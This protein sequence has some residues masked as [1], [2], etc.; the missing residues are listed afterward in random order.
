MPTALR[1]SVFVIACL[2]LS[3]G[4]AAFAAEVAV[5]ESSAPAYEPGKTLD[6]AS[7]IMLTAEQ[8]I[9][10]ATE[11]GRILRLEGPRDAP[12]A[13][14]LEGEEPATGEVIGALAR[15]VGQT[16]PEAGGLAGVRG[17]DDETPLDT[18][19]EAWLIHIGRQ[20]NQCY[21]SD[22]P[23]E[24]WRELGRSTVV[25]EITDV[26]GGGTATVEWASQAQR[27]PWPLSLGPVDGR[28]YL[29]RGEDAVRSTAVTLRA[30]P[31]EIDEHE[32]AAVAWLAAEGCARQ[33]R[34]LLA[35]VVESEQPQ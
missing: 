34:L 2:L 13:A 3:V 28:V 24:L 27:A 15:L 9:V 22:A 33:A 23:V 1:K 26:A 19:P 7:P 20:G 30:L 18:R 31:P 12:L 14:E 4:G 11:D 32:L 8:F 10:V 35:Q 6:P 5:I 17:E 29:L 25:S 21:L 16:G